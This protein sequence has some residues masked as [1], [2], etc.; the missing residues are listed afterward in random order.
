MKRIR[1][2]TNLFIASF[3][4]SG[5]IVDMSIGYH[6]DVADI[7]WF[8]TFFWGMAVCHLSFSL[9]S[10]PRTMALE[11]G[12]P[13][14]ASSYNA[15]LSRLRSNSHLQIIRSASGYFLSLFYWMVSMNISDQGRE[16]FIVPVAVSDPFWDL[17][18]VVEAFKFPGV[19]RVCRM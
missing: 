12:L 13:V 17:Y 11:A 10:V 4:A 8:F 18:F 6:N 5:F 9:L 14:T 15:E 3:T 16:V 1:R 19:D 2:I 7:I